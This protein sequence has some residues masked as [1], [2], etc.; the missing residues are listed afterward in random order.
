MGW[1]IRGGIRGGMRDEGETRIS[2]ISC[3]RRDARKHTV[4]F[5][6]PKRTE[7]LGI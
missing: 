3:R 5:K 6:D 2:E 7:R 1:G 4:P